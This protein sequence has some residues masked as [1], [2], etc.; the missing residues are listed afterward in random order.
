MSYVDAPVSGG[1]TGAINGTLTFMVGSENEDIFNKCKPILEGMGK[2][3]FN[4]KKS[5]GGQ[6]VKLAN[7]MSLA[8]QMIGLSESLAMAER[9]GMDPN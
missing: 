1:V 3:F 6:I 2:N 5:G 4:C 8:I 9:L 7:N